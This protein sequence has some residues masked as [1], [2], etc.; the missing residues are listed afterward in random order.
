MQKLNHMAYMGSKGKYHYFHHYRISMMKREYRVLKDELPID[1]PFPLTEDKSQW[2]SYMVVEDESRNSGVALI[3]YR[4]ISRN[5]E[6]GSP[7]NINIL[8]QP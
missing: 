2:R 6:G 7:L 1:D 5:F 8:A 3:S 4:D